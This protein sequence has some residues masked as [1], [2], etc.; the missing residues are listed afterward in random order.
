MS[1]DSVSS[2]F[3]GLETLM[4][5]QGEAAE[6]TEDPLGRDAFL[7]MLIAQLENQDPLNPMEGNDFSAQLAQFSS[8]EQLFNVNDTLETIAAGQDAKAGEN[9]LE[10]IGKQVMIEDDT[11]KLSDGAVAGGLFTLETPAEMM[12]SIYDE[13]GRQLISLYPGQMDAGT[14]QV[15]WNGFDRT[16][17]PVPDGSYR[18]ALTAIDENGIYT[19]VAAAVSGLVTGVTYENGTPYLDLDGHRVDPGT[20]VKVWSQAEGA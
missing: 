2:K 11:L 5:S 17:V 12:I 18:F 19:P 13:Y 9:V 16:G 8:L 6:K 1:I 3:P 15:S 7:K 10:Y 4:Q 20:V 14:H